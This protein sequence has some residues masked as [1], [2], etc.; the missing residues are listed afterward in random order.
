VTAKRKPAKPK[1]K[2]P[3][4]SAVRGRVE[5][6]VSHAVNELRKA[7]LLCQ[8]T[9]MCEMA[10]QLRITRMMEREIHFGGVLL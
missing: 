9:G 4:F 8:S 5:H 2:K 10:A 7:A 6:H 3:K 1:P